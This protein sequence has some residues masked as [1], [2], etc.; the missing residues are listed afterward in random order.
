MIHFLNQL[1]E[2]VLETIK[3]VVII[4]VFKRA[5]KDL[6]DFMFADE[7]DYKTLL[8]ALWEAAQQR[9]RKERG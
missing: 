4:L 2:Q 6:F 1:P 9:L 7:K 8:Q 3:W 5:I